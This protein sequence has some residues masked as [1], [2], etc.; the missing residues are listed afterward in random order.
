MGYGD[1]NNYYTAGN[2]VANILGHSSEN[3]LPSILLIVVI[4]VV[5]M[6]I[7]GPVSYAILKKKDKRELMWIIIPI[8]VVVFSVT[9]FMYGY[10]SRGGGN[11]A[12]TLTI[13]ELNP[14]SDLQKPAYVATTVMTSSNGNYKISYDNDALFGSNLFE[15][16]SDHYMTSE[17]SKSVEYRQDIKS[18]ATVKGA[19]MW[20]FINAES[21]VDVKNYGRIETEFIVRENGN[22]TIRLKNN[23]G[24]DLKRWL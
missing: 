21:V 10:L 22:M 9:I 6:L 19:T 12:S 16:E 2:T 1:G 4:I 13:V 11:V 14:Y 18:S 20:S 15:Y 5:Y 3:F 17:E 7:V 24:Y 8:V 23:T